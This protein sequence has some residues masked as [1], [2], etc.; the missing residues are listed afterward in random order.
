MCFLL[1]VIDRME[2]TALC[3]AL[4]VLAAAAADDLVRFHLHTEMISDKVHGAED[5][6][7]GIP[8]AAA[9]PSDFADGAEGFGGHEVA[10]APGLRRKRGSPCDQGDKDS[11]ADPRAAGTPEAAHSARNLFS[12]LQHGHQ[13]LF[14]IHFAAGVPVRGEQSRADHGMVFR[15]FP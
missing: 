15:A 5:G 12:A 4:V 13:P 9:R 14:Q 10:E 1:P 6:E 8:L 2:G 3:D 11:R 7:V